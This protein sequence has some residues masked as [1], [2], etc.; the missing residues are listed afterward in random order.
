MCSGISDDLQQVDGSRKTAIIDRELLRLNIGIAAL[1][2]NRLTSSSS[3]RKQNHMFFWQS[4]EPEEPWVH[5]VGFPVR[6]PL[7]SSAERPSVA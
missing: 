6:N 5:G 1:Q 7:L 4:K 2:A 3:L